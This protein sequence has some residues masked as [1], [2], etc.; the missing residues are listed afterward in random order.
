MHVEYML[1]FD[2]KPG[3]PNPTT[4]EMAEMNRFAKRLAR[5]G[6]LRRGAPLSSDDAGAR[7]RV[8]GGERAITDGPF[9]ES[10]EVIAGFWIV[11]VASRDE[12]LEIARTC[13]HARTG[14]V[15]VHPMRNR[16]TFPDSGRDTAWLLAFQQEQGSTDPD[17]AKM[18]A[19]IE[20]GTELVRQGVQL[21]TAP[22]ASDPPPARV[23]PRGGA[24]GVTDG[25]F[26]EAKEVIAGYSLVRAAS[27]AA[28]IDIAARFPHAQWGTVE[29]REILF[30][31]ET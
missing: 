22:L 20:F 19:M 11:E 27:R 2:G 9:A 10:K 25:P 17:N 26:A 23:E 7:I 13:P 29:V 16:F 24:I 21:E 4:A 5:E 12:A 28:A 18:R 8:R 31:D 14:V 3:A 15:E 1:V 30:F 6:R